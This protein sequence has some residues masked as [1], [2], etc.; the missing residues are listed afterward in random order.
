MTNT[1]P[2]VLAWHNSA[3]LKATVAHTGYMS[4]ST[5]DPITVATTTQAPEFH[6]ALEEDE[7]VPVPA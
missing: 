1:I 7:D 6:V 5:L 3:R 2:P 4:Q